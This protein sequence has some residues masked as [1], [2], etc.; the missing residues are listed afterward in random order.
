MALPQPGSFDKKI[1]HGL[2]P[3]ARMKANESVVE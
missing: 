2:L 1:T 3:V